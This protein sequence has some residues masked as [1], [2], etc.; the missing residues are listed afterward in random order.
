MIF[1]LSLVKQAQE[2]AKEFEAH[3]KTLSPEDAEKLKQNRREEWEKEDAHRKKIEI[4]KAG[5]SRNF[6]GNY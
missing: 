1:L 6:W 4:A 5:R 2:E 3:C